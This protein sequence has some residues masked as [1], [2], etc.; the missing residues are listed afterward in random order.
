MGKGFVKGELE[1][2]KPVICMVRQKGLLQPKD[3]GICTGLLQ[4]RE[5]KAGHLIE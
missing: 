2:T 3:Y 4:T 5:K 1:Y